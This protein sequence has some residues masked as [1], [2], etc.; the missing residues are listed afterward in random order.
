MKFYLDSAI[1]EEIAEAVKWG[2]LDGVTTNPTLIA[3][4]GAITKSRSSASAGS[5]GTSRP[6][7]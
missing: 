4:A 2:V 7:S 3:K 1:Y 6:R 5:S